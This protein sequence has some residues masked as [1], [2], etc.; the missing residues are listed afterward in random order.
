VTRALRFRRLA[1]S[2]GTVALGVLLGLAA[3]EG[4]VRVTGVDHRYVERHV[5]RMVGC[6]DNFEVDPDPRVRYRGRR[7][8][9][10]CLSETV[11]F[12]SL[13]FRG[14]ERPAAKPPGVTRVLVVGGS[15]VFGLRVDDAGTWPAQLERRLNRDRPGRYEVWNGGLP[16]Y[17][18]SQG[19]VAAE[20]A[21]SVAAFDAVIF[22]LSNADDFPFLKDTP[23]APFFEREPALW[24]EVVAPPLLAFPSGTSPAFRR[25]LIGHFRLYR[26]GLLAATA[27]GARRGKWAQYFAFGEDPDVL[28]RFVAAH[29]EVRSCVFLCPGCGRSITSLRP[30]Y[31][32]LTV[33]FL[34]LR[35]ETLPPPF[36]AI[37]PSFQVMTWYADK[38]AAWLWR[39]GLVPK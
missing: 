32:G 23:V 28:R 13:G 24:K 35:D 39:E 2:V 18:T 7:G 20:R 10:E 14:P 29:P 16:G 22:A 8:V 4:I 37:H 6:A 26:T 17:V 36:H 38:L 30:L 19:V 9:H 3:G 33:P 1:R 27:L 25:A 15:N 11:T 34:D 21:L 5:F 31:T 12:N